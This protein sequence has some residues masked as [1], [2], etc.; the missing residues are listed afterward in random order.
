MATVTTREQETAARPR[1]ADTPDRGER[2]WQRWVRLIPLVIGA[3]VF[4]FPFYYM[5]VSALQKEPNPDISGA[6]P[7]PAKLS[8]DNLVAINNAI[9]LPRTLLNSSL[10]TGGVLLATL[11]LGVLAGYALAQL[12]F[13][14]RQVVF[15][16]MIL[17]LVLPFQL[18]IIPLYVLI[19]RD[20][21]LADTLVGMILPF[22]INPTAVFIFRQFFLQL[23][24]EMFE[25]ARIDGASELTVLTR[26]VLPLTRPAVLTALLITFIGPWNEFLWPFLITKRLELEPLAV[27]LANYISTVAQLAANPYGTILA[28]ATVL[29]VPVV[30]LFLI[31]QRR[32]VESA[33]GSA[34]KG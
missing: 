26:V 8:L 2:G 28:G 20:F 30:V 23:P 13:R 3:L 19:A 21:G 5:V 31:F 16:T 27:A 18:L 4:V 34:V 33:I 1:R 14:G 25:A 15:Y 9:N 11:V 29:A 22:A 6:F 24:K 7:N 12:H 17:L 10:F 32:F